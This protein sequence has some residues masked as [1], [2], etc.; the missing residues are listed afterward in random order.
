[1]S[2]IA[3]LIL[4]LFI[5]TMVVTDTGI[6]GRPGED[7]L[8]SQSVDPRQGDGRGGW[9]VSLQFNP[10]TGQALQDSRDYSIPSARLILDLIFKDWM[11]NPRTKE[12]V[13]SYLTNPDIPL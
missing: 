5:L 9:G 2:R 1:M 13:Y 6:G 8:L 3:V 11:T 12:C 4:P 7:S 10:T